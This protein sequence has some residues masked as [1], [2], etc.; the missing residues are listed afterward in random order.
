MIAPAIA[1]PYLF[2]ASVLLAPGPSIGRYLC[3]P[4]STHRLPSERMTP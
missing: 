3:C 2:L 1:L 4:R